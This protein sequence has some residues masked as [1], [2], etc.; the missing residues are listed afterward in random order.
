MAHGGWCQTHIGVDTRTDRQR[1]SLRSRALAY[2]CVGRSTVVATS[3]STWSSECQGFPAIRDTTPHENRN[4]SSQREHHY[5]VG[6]Y[7]IRDYWRFLE[8][9]GR[10]LEI[11]GS[12]KHFFRGNN[13][14][15]MIVTIYTT[16]PVHR[17]AHQQCV[18]G[19]HMRI[20]TLQLLGSYS[21]E[22]AL[23]VIFPLKRI[24]I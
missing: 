3:A 14:S 1:Y 7:W 13:C 4:T 22:V 20:C 11:T 5:R 15:K 6:D 12:L 8:V 9:T 17:S 10:L 2:R 23:G 16:F 18:T 24:K 21:S 19:A